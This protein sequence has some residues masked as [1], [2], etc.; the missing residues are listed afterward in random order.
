MKKKIAFI[1]IQQETNAFSP[2]L[3][4]L[5]DFKN[6]HY[7]LDDEIVQVVAQSK[8]QLGGFYK[9]VR[10]FGQEQIE[11]LPMVCAWANSGGPLTTE[12][13]AH[14]KDL[15]QEKLS[16]HS[17][18]AGIFL[19][20]HGA[21]CVENH[22]DAEGLMLEHIRSWV[23]PE[24]WIGMPLDLHGNITQRMVQ[25]ASFIT[26]YRTN[27]HRDHFR[28]G[29]L[30]AQMLI[31]AVLGKTKPVMAVEKLPLLKGGGYG[32]DFLSPNRQ[33]FKKMRQ[34][35]R[36]KGVLAVATFMVHIW[37]DDPELGWATVVVTDNNQAQA[38]A[39]ARALAQAN[40]D[41]R[42]H[43]HPMPCTAD[44]A[45]QQVQRAWWR[46]RLGVVILADLSDSVSAGA[47][48]ENTHVIRA[49]LP[50]A[51]QLRCY[52]SICDSQVASEAYALPEGTV[53]RTTLGG[54][55]ENTYNQPLDF[56][57]IVRGKWHSA[58][59]GQVVVLQQQGLF[60][61]VSEHPNPVFYPAFYRNLG[62][63]LWKAD[64]IVVKNI[65]PFRWFYALYNRLTIN[66]MTPGTTL[67][68]VFQLR[69]QHI[70][71][72]IYPLDEA[73]Q[74]PASTES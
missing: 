60:V 8:F 18:L 35:E 23:G 51:A 22:S 74:W 72:P 20:M 24:V 17:D 15:L 27:P 19:S 54:K 11:V 50:F 37:I 59:T 45:M 58:Y 61:V 71:R 29:Y 70:P 7:Y 67:I 52:A 5:D 44:E 33:I 36:Q 14:F 68:D 16:K 42:H 9:A 57:G 13:F 48:G 65:F 62:L 55:R 53:L 4:T 63:N 64:A 73:V 30:N 6:F 49:M 38:Q 25:H 3:T 12:T 26:A 47:P 32:I 69:Y 31:D 2:I 10:D 66:V 21:M 56:E 39:G 40:W 28:V 1:E 41:I 34:M 43:R 46:R